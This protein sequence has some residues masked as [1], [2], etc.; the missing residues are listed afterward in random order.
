MTL[1]PRSAF[2]PGEGS[3]SAPSPAPLLG[4]GEGWGEGLCWIHA[5]MTVCKENP[6]DFRKSLGFR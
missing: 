5:L 1:L 2:S 6:K 3:D 4:V